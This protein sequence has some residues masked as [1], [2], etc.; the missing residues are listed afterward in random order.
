[1]NSAAMLMAFLMLAVPA[2]AGSSV[3]VSEG[4]SLSTGYCIVGCTAQDV[5]ADADGTLSFGVPCIISYEDSGSLPADI[6]MIFE[7]DDLDGKMLRITYDDG[8]SIQTAY[9]TFD[10]GSCCITLNEI[11]SGTDLR[12]TGYVLDSEPAEIAMYV[13]AYPEG[14]EHMSM[15][16]L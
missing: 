11:R 13:L 9:G 1:M 5:S 14:S 16:S 7:C 4:N 8:A 2:A 3:Y 6:E 15:W 10:W 12:I